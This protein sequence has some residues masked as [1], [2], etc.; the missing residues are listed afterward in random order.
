LKHQPL[1]GDDF[2]FGKYFDHEIFVVALQTLFAQTHQR[3]ELLR[4]FSSIK[5][6]EI[7]EVADNGISQGV[8]AKAGVALVKAVTIPS[9]IVLKPF[10]TFRE[11]DQPESPFVVRVKKGTPLPQVALFECDGGMWKLEAMSRI[12]D[13]IETYQRTRA[14]EFTLRII[15]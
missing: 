10:R 5:T 4:I 12:V 11:I 14:I 7:L 15:A 2:H 13:A 3:D 6:E 9:P 8:V 1:F